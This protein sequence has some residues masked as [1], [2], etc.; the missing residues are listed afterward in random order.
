MN[1]L[2]CTFFDLIDA[3]KIPLTIAAVA[4]IA[5]TKIATPFFPEAAQRNQQA[6]RGVIMGVLLL[7]GAT[8]IVSILFGTDASTGC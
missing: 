4:F 2:V 1:N 5:L 7:V 8:W 6:L 3:V